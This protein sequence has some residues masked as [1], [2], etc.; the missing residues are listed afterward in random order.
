[1]STVT[2]SVLKEFVSKASALHQTWK[3]SKPSASEL[4]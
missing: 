2:I 3:T 4:S 1:M